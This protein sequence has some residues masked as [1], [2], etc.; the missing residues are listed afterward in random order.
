MKRIMAV[1]ALVWL[2][3]S[4]AAAQ[5][6]QGDRVV[7][8]ARNSSRPRLVKVE[9]HNG[10]VS[11]KAYNGNEVIVETRGRDRRP[12]TNRDG[13]RQI[14]LPPSGLEVEEED[15]VVTVR[16]ASSSEG[17]V[18]ISVPANTS[19]NI[20]AHN[21]AITVEG[22]HGEISAQSQNGKINLLNVGGSVLANTHNEEVKVILD[23]VDPSKPLSFASWNG[24]VDVTLPADFKANVK[25]KC[26][27]GDIWSDFDVKLSPS[28]TVTEKSNRPD[29]R[30]RVRTDSTYSGTINGGGVDA[31]FSTY[32][33]SIYI[34]KAK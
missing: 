22:V 10:G 3:C 4:L 27:N 8:P 7:V 16:L 11:V 15:N 9:T 23:R 31:S 21:G 18:A 12:R 24:T 1:S 28:P 17:D 14:L 29:G 30:F 19:L 2:T 26:H 5:D 20:E 6:I 13:M 25:L 34:R 32:N 33:G